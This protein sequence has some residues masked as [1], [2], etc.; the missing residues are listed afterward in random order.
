MRTESRHGSILGFGPLLLCV[1]SAAG[2]PQ[3]SL[4]VEESVGED[5]VVEGSIGAQA[6]HVTNHTKREEVTSSGV[7]PCQGRGDTAI[8]GAAG[9]GHSLAHS[10]CD[11]GRQHGSHSQCEQVC[12]TSR[13]NS[14]VVRRGSS[15]AARRHRQHRAALDDATQHQQLHQVTTQ[16]SGTTESKVDKCVCGVLWQDPAC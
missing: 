3:T 1:S 4:G 9:R 15:Q 8:I 5:R 16:R 7:T 11:R 2:Q 14:G 6:P 12:S 13:E 10:A